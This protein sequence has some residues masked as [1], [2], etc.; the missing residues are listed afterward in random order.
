MKKISLMALGLIAGLTVSAQPEV[1]K[2]AE[3]LVKK[4]DY[5]QA[6][7]QVQPALT[8]P[9]TMNT[10]QPWYIAGEA[11]VGLWD[12]YTLA[13]M[14]G[15]QATPEQTKAASKALVDAYNYFVKALPLDQLP[16]EKGKVKPKYT[17][18]IQKII[19]ENYHNYMQAGLNLYNT[20]DYPDAYEAW[21]IYVNMPQNDK[22]DPKAYVADPDSLV[23]QIAYY[24]GL[25]AYFSDN[26]EGALQQLDKALGMGFHDKTAYILG[27][28]GS[29]KL[30]RT[31]DANRYARE[32]NKL[33]GADDISFLAQLINS[34]LEN[35]NYPACYEA[36]D[37][38]FAI[39]ANDSIKSQLYNV[40]AIINERENK[41]ADAKSN[42]EESIKLNPSNAKS[43][44]DMGRLIQN[45]VAAQ[46]ENADEPTRQNVLVPALKKAIEFYE[47]SYDLDDTQDQLSKYIYRLY[48]QLD[49]NY[50][51]GEEYA[52]KAEEWSLK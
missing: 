27:V 21:D 36:I 44:F 22:A 50:H 48:Y 49:Q 32:G 34:E 16:D 45:E 14:G 35:N 43:Y 15:Q 3:S 47:K 6:L 31:A 37:E 41:I 42:L 9:S 11:A 13:G 7:Q 2:N 17:K 30:K 18:K 51:L 10:A 1:V 8:D 24:Q 33:Y 20:Q 12:D 29:N 39:A 28:E 38:S 19:G 26:I 52:K 46:E 40:R 4:K 25:A 23:G 5:A